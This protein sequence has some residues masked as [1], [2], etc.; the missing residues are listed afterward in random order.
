VYQMLRETLVWHEGSGGSPVVVA[1]VMSTAVVKCGKGPAGGIT[2]APAQRSLDGTAQVGVGVGVGVDVAVAVGVNVAVAV[3]VGVNVAVAVAVAVAV[4]VGVNVAVAVGVGVGVGVGL[5]QVVPTNA[6][7]RL[8]SGPFIK[9]ISVLAPVAILIVN[10]LP[11][12][13]EPY[14]WP[15][16]GL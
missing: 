1:Q 4:G 6:S 8:R 13:S 15:F 14:S 16:V 3:G 11:L 2:M 12:R 7:P 10:K 5:G 9:P